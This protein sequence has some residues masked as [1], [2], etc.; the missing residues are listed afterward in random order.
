MKDKKEVAKELFDKIKYILSNKYNNNINHIIHECLVQICYQGLKD[1]KHT[2]GNLTAQVDKLCC[3]NKFTPQDT[4]AV[5]A[6]RIRSNSISPIN[7]NDLLYDCRALSLLI[8]TV[9]NDKIP[10]YIHNKLPLTP[11]QNTRNLNKKIKKLRGIVR[12]FND[13]DIK[14]SIM[15]YADEIEDFIVRYYDKDNFTNF[16]YLDRILKKGMQLNLLDCN[17]KNNIIYAD[18]IIIEPDFI[19]DV[20]TIANCFEEYG[21]HPLLY[22]IKRLKEGV[23]NK[24][25]VFGN[26]AS[27]LLDNI[28]N[29]NN[30]DNALPYYLRNSALEIAAAK[31]IDI[32]EL[33]HNAEEQAINIQTITKEILKKYDNSKIIIEPT[34]ICEA[35]G[36][37][38]RIDLMTTDFKLIVEQKSGKN[39]FLEN[40]FSNKHGSLHIE[41]HY[42]QLLLYYSLIIHNFTID[43]SKKINI[44]LLYSKYNLPK[45]FLEVTPFKKLIFEAIK[46][47][48]QIVST[49]FWLSR[50]SCEKLFRNLKASSLITEAIN[51]SFFQKYIEPQLN[52][53]I[54]N[55]QK[56]NMLESAYFSRMIRFVIKEEI[57]SKVGISEYTGNAM[58]DLWNM[59]LKTK[60]DTGNILTDL[61]VINKE[62]SSEK[63]GYDI[64]TLKNKNKCDEFIPNFRRGDMIIL[65]KYTSEKEIDVRSYILL[66]GT[67]IDIETQNIKIQLNN[68]QKNSEFITGFPYAIEHATSNINTSI[69]I[70]GLNTLAKANNDRRNLLLAQ[71]RP[72]QNKNVTLNKY[73]NKYYDEIVLKA[74]Q[75]K[76]YFLIIGPP[77]TGK[78]SMALQFIVREHYNDNI[79]LMAYTNRAVDEICQILEDNNFEYIRLGNENSTGKNFIHRLINNSIKDTTDIDKI[80]EKIINTN[81]IVSTTATLSNKQ[82]ILNIKHFQL[83]IIDEASQILEPNLIGILA[84]KDFNDYNAIDKFILIG[85][86]KQLPAVVLQDEKESKVDNIQLND[87]KLYNCADSLFQRLIRIEKSANRTDFIGTLNRQGRMHPEIAEFPNNMFYKNENIKTVPLKHQ[88][89]EKLKYNINNNNNLIDKIL[90]ENRLIFIPVTPIKNYYL[91]EKNNIKEAKIIAKIVKHLYYIINNKFN[92]NKSIGIIVPYRSQISMIKKEI[93]LFHI[94]ELKQITIDTVERYQGSQRDVIIFSTTIKN[95]SQLDFLTANTFTE[96]G[97]KID[98]KLNVAITRAKQQLIITGNENILKVNDIYKK[99]IEFISNKKGIFDIQNILYK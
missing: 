48:N 79:L 91:S 61:K 93:E 67:I 60:L 14:I 45:G 19:M 26:F 15:N 57:L 85:D 96:D 22:I 5:H 81:I 69:A 89:E 94:K 27:M 16:K 13:K 7:E 28:V 86:Y 56:L 41:K 59:P 29:Y 99:L 88:K 9:F 51:P 76:D 84:A 38:G 2:F 83:A 43:D 25:T 78:T 33:K 73:Y 66:K 49:E 58:A 39:F 63:N 75:A 3:D 55:I 95:I 18:L 23:N 70:S 47:R 12:E 64:I 65:Y 1:S 71:R 98:R 21:H 77:G 17:I 31:D 72:Q 44:F 40:N 82:Y 20:S 90:A 87:I 37:Q 24:Y 4:A 42:V 50:N 62:K 36:L 34:F 74:K 11:K 30:Y 8:S 80:K 46:F 53:T 6:M 35:L 68:G 10:K 52:N 54:Q 32:N 97:I 92:P